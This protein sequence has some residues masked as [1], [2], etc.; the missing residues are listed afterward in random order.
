MTLTIL[1]LLSFV[2]IFPY[3]HIDPKP[4]YRMRKLTPI[5]FATVDSSSRLSISGSSNLEAQNNPNTQ[6]SS[7]STITLSTY[8][9]VLLTI[10]SCLVG[11]VFSFI[12]SKL[13]NAERKG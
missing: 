1:F 4:A 8:I 13:M 10:L 11:A 9:F 7:S 12:C 5:A 3:D 2:F 6:V